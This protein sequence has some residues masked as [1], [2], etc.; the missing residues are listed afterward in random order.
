MSK[1]RN[2]QIE[3]L[4]GLTILIVM[5]YH[6]F[7][8]YFQLYSDAKID[9]LQYWGSIGV[10]I[11]FMISAYYLG[12]EA[13]NNFSLI[14]YLKKKLLRLWPGYV[15]AITI[16]YIFTHLFFLPE[17]TVGIKD[18]LLNLFFVSGYIGTAYVDGS[19]W[20]LYV[21]VPIIII[22]GISKKLKLNNY[23]SFYI[24]WIC[25]D[26]LLIKTEHILISHLFGYTYLGVVVVGISWFKLR[27]KCSDKTYKVK[28]F[29]LC[30]LGT[31]FTYK[32]LHF[33]GLIELLLTIIL[34][35]LV[36]NL[37]LPFLEFQ[38]FQ[39]LGTISYYIYLV[40]Q[41]ISF[42]I[43]YNLEK[44]IGVNT[45]FYG[46]IALAISIIFAWIVWKLD[47]KIRKMELISMLNGLSN[48]M[49]KRKYRAKE[50]RWKRE[51]IELTLGENN[52]RELIIRK[53]PLSRISF[54]GGIVV[55]SNV[56]F[57]LSE[58]GI[59]QIDKDVF[60]NDG[61]KIN[62][63][64]LVHIGE[65]TIIGQNVLIYDH[66]HDYRSGDRRN[67]FITAPIII[68]KNVWIGSGVII[69]KGVSIGDNSVIAAG[70]IVTK[71]VPNDVLYYN[72]LGE[73][74]YK[75]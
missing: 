8:R 43:I 68:G 56:I 13:E 42:S 66:D 63:R 19:H 4:R 65:G 47:C 58:Q 3:G 11:F 62:V 16:T 49:K 31:A 44:S 7:Y 45:L 73:A 72:K 50:K 27:T 25:C 36:L 14:Q 15:I 22:C 24:L 67:K 6:I 21:L 32:F 20:Y 1:N 30:S 12:S 51:N 28:W 59:L 46:V 33:E 41:N 52:L 55:R 64:E 2:L 69:L 29:L 40:H 9:A 10:M 34:L 70:S 5:I 57:N 54:L 39:F 26:Y 35:L 17:R 71:D 18:Y 23:C 60:I 48:R 53:T 61:T 75:R 37:K 38:S 74:I